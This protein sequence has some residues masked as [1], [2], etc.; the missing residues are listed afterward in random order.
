[1]LIISIVALSHIYTQNIDESVLNESY[2]SLYEKI[3]ASDEDSAQQRFFLEAYLKKAKTEKNWERII[4]GYKFYLHRVPKEHKLVYAD[5]MIYAARE[6]KEQQLI[7]SAILTKGIVYYS[8]KQYKKALDNYLLANDHFAMSRSKPEYLEYKIKY[9]LGHINYYLEEYNVAIKLMEECR[10]YFKG[11]DPKPYLNTLHYIGLC[12][13]RMK[14]SVSCSEVN[15]QGIKEGIELGE[16]SR[17]IYFTHSE[18][19]NQYF[20]K[21]YS[22]AIDSLQKTLLP[23]EKLNDFGNVTLGHYYIGA[24]YWHLGNTK[25]AISHLKLVDQSFTDH[26][27][28]KREFLD[29]Y[30]IL[31]N[32]YKALG[33]SIMYT[34]YIERKLEATD[35]IMKRNSY[36]FSKVK[37]EY[38]PWKDRNAQNSQGLFSIILFIIALIISVLFL[39]SGFVFLFDQYSRDAQDNHLKKIPANNSIP[40]KVVARVHISHETKSDLIKQLDK[41]EKQEKYLDKNLSLST[42]TTSFSTNMNYLSQVIKQQRGKN[43]SDYINDLR[44]NYIIKS[45][46]ENKN[47]K[48]Y[49]IK[50]LADAAGYSDA[51][52][53][54]KYFKIKTGMLPSYYIRNIKNHT[55]E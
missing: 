55:T 15:Q 10:N 42:L 32:Y 34:H 41:F 9:N 5:S 25:K 24:S 11:K 2:T 52:L 13:V 40:E 19:V 23:I 54:A 44:I 43:F 39:I 53:F 17:E 30:T 38:I 47:F 27:Y 4:K 33:D 1:M 28:I 51:R 21:N 8:Q 35:T 46:N 31:A 36:L 14:N 37:N 26:N 16:R 45:L 7:A 49:K 18:G 20:M 3:K 6:S 50:S 29:G 12:H 48:H 22:A